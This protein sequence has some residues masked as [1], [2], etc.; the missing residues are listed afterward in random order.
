MSLGAALV[1]L[2]LG[3][4]RT[5][6]DIQTPQAQG[7]TGGTSSPPSWIIKALLAVVAALGLVHTPPQAFKGWQGHL[8]DTTEPLSTLPSENTA[9]ILLI[10]KPEQRVPSAPR[11]A[12]PLKVFCSHPSSS[13]PKLSLASKGL[14]AT[15]G[16]C[17]PH[18]YT[19]ALLLQEGYEHTELAQAEYKFSLQTT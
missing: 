1:I 10:T 15:C 8:R 16:T 5:D 2:S 4:L 3:V 9:V 7:D 14:T 13:I 11:A 19:S 17:V 12:Q 18:E 6:P